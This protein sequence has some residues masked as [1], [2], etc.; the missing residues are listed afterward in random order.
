VVLP[1]D[2]LPPLEPLRLLH[3]NSGAML[4]FGF[5]PRLMQWWDDTRS[6]E[7]LIARG[8]DHRIAPISTYKR[9]I[10][11]CRPANGPRRAPCAL[12]VELWGLLA[13]AQVPDAHHPQPA[14]AACDECPQPIPA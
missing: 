1:L 10:T 8:P 12:V 3:R 7:P 9:G 11:L 13:G 6:V 14:R 2:P 5:R 4:L